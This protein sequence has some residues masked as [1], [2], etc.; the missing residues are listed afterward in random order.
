MRKT[1]LLIFGI[2]ILQVN[3]S[4][5][6]QYSAT[7]LNNNFTAEQISDLKKITDFFKKEMCL[8]MDS[9][10]KTCYKQIP[11]EYL[12]ATGNPFWININFEK[13]KELYKQISKSTFDEIWM[14]CK[15]RTYPDGLESK[16]LCANATGKYQKFLSD[17][18]G[19]NP[20]VAKYA[21]GINASGDFSPMDFHYWNVLKIKKYFDLDDPNIQLILAIH[22]LS[23]N[24]QEK[25]KDK[26]EEE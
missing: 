13:Q 26:W 19:I 14:F 9:D 24:D 4:C 22:Y 5:K 20:R 12:E 15:S 11:H 16:S 8:Y 10:F 1:V 3:S 25:R 18:G 7:E 17:L 2:T 23:L 6:S 21:E